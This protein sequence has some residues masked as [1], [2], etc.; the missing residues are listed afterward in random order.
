MSSLAEGLRRAGRIEAA[1]SLAEQAR[2]TMVRLLPPEHVEVC[3]AEMTVADALRD[4]GRGDEAIPIYEQV[5]D[6]LADRRPQLYATALLGLGRTY[7]AL[8][9]ADDATTT[10]RQAQR[11]LAGVEHDPKLAEDVATALT[12]VGD[13]AAD[14]DG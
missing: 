7:A 4:A 13:A 8:G 6:K 11:V 3:E 14:A 9:R 2:D 10:L 1:V 12:A 5:V